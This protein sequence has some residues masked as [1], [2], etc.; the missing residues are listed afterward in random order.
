MESPDY[1]LFPNREDQLH[2]LRAYLEESAVLRG[3]DPSLV[4]E[5]DVEELYWEVQHFVPVSEIDRVC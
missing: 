2:W 5:R 3:S 1:S 4:S